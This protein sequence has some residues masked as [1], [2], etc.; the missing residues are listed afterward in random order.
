MPTLRGNLS[1][2]FPDFLTHLLDSVLE[3][4]IILLGIFYQLPIKAEPDPIMSNIDSMS[5]TATAEQLNDSSAISDH[6]NALR[7]AARPFQFLREHLF[8]ISVI[9]AL[10]FGWSHRNDNYLSAEN[11]TGYFL[12]IIGGSLMLLVILYPLSK[13]IP[14]LSRWLPVRHWFAIHM[15]F[16]IV[17]PVLI[18][19]HSNFH[20]GSTNSSV[21]LTTMLLVAGSGLVGRYIY[22]HIHHGLYGRRVTLD[23][24]K[25]EL[26]TRHTALLRIYEMDEKLK[27]RVTR[28][29]NMALSSYTS[30][31]TSLLYVFSMTIHARLLKSRSMRM[32]KKSK[33][34]G[35]VPEELDSQIA[36]NFINR[37]AGA[38]RRITVFRLYERLFSLWHILHLPLFIMMIITAVIHIFAV[39]MY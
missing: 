20:L 4:I 9:A 8:S 30:I 34:D 16:G 35:T 26:E 21:A 17:G 13:R 28:M 2:T 29:E 18:L 38:L 6:K 36:K 33:K 39:H 19:F 10:L 32:V 14:L 1:D 27:H 15:L 23:E 11:G 12:G 24:L 31:G 22:T 25:H 3:A 37:Y 7:L 5:S